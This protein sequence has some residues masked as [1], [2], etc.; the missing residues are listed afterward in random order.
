MKDF[1]RPKIINRKKYV[2]YEDEMKRL[3][4][5]SYRL[6][7]RIS[8]A[9][10]LSMRAGLRFN[11]IRTLEWKDLI[12]NELRLRDTKSGEEQSVYLPKDLIDKIEKLRSNG[13]KRIFEWNNGL[14]SNFGANVYFKKVLRLADIHKRLTFHD[15][16]HTCATDLMNHDVNLHIIKQILRH[17][18]IHTTE[19]Y[20]HTAPTKLLEAAKKHSLAV[21]N[22]T[23]DDLIKE[24]V[25]FERTILDTSFK[26][27]IEYRKNEVIIKVAY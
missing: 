18:D 4:N 21:K 26:P 2:L 3:L 22:W 27:S 8:V 12:D 20:L 7:Y 1:K 10:E 24:I 23:K 16:R 15:L 6:N 11:E 14:L 25:K 19:G 5:V 9:I 17:K 13:H